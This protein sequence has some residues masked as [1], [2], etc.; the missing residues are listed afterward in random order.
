LPAEI[1]IETIFSGAVCAVSLRANEARA[2]LADFASADRDEVKRR[3]GM[4]PF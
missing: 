1:A 4:A 3:N 2:V